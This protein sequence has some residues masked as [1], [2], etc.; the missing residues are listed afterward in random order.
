MP[1]SLNVNPELLAAAAAQADTESQNVFARH[2]AAD[3]AVDAALYGWVGT[4]R[5]A[6]AEA[7]Q[8]WAATTT[9]LTAR[10]YR[11]GEALR[12]SGLTY[13]EMAAAHARALSGTGP[14]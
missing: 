12:I 8:C 4:S 5:A 2:S 11:H 13:A 9:A 10:L 7:A 1:G 6:L 14:S 3:A